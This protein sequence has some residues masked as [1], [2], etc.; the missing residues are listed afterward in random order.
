MGKDLRAPGSPW[1]RELE[2]SQV[3]VRIGNMTVLLGTKQSHDSYRASAELLVQL[4]GPWWAILES[5]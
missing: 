3:A 5:C 4:T 2:R 1:S